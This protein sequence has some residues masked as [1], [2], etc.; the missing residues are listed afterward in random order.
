MSRGL[1]DPD[2]VRVCADR[3]V[4]MP[5]TTTSSCLGRRHRH[6]SPRRADARHGNVNVVVAVPFQ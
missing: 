3:D 2:A 5:T 4:A 6:T 1:A